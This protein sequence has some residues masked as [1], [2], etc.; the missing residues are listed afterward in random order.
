MSL[1]NI[2]P[3]QAIRIQNIIK[4]LDCLPTLQS[5]DG[6]AALFDQL[7][8]SYGVVIYEYNDE[9]YALFSVETKAFLSGQDLDQKLAKISQGY[10]Y[11]PRVPLGTNGKINSVNTTPNGP[12]PEILNKAIKDLKE[13]KLIPRDV[14]INL[15]NSRMQKAQTDMAGLSPAEMVLHVEGIMLE[16]FYCQQLASAAKVQLYRDKIGKAVSNFSEKKSEKR[17]KLQ[18]MIAERD[19]AKAKAKAASANPKV[20]KVEKIKLT[21]M[22]KAMAAM[23]LDYNNPE[24]VKQHQEF[25]A[26][27]TKK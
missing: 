25:L 5:E 21:S 13:E 16:A 23:G 12:N 26:G 8:D 20:Q 18:K 15:A 24:E 4:T 1:S 27:L 3:T 7:I 19:A 9:S 17:T 14:H 6:N 22:Q 10:N 11:M 2:S